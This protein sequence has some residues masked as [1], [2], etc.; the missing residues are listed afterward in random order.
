LQES[1]FED[2]AVAYKVA[3]EAAAQ[4]GIRWYRAYTLMEWAEALISGAGG[5]A[6]EQA[7]ALL[8]EA[9]SEFEAMGVTVYAQEITTRLSELSPR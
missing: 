7:R 1:R 5:Q 9:R 4:C 2:A 3:A 8:E 6:G